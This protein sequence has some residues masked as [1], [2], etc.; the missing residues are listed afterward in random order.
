MKKISLLFPSAFRYPSLPAEWRFGL[1]AARGFAHE[2][3]EDFLYIV[4]R[5]DD[6]AALAGVPYR[7]ARAGQK[8]SL[9]RL[10]LLSLYYFVWLL[11]FFLAHPRWRRGTLY[12]TERKI[13]LGALLLRAIFRFPYKV[14]FESHSLEEPWL[15]RFLYRHADHVIFVTRVM[16]DNARREGLITGEKSFSVLAAAVNMMKFEGVTRDPAELRSD[17]NLPENKKIVLFAGRFRAMGSDKG[18]VPLIKIAGALSDK[19]IVFCFVGGTGKEIESARAEARAEGVEERCI[20]VPFV[21][22]RKIIRYLLAADAL[23][24]LPPREKFFLYETSPMKLFEYMAAGKPIILA[25]YP[26]LREALA[27][28][29]AFFVDPDDRDALT[30]V[31]GEA[32]SGSPRAAAAARA[33]AA[34]AAGNT[35]EERAKK[36]IAIAAAL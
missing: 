3:G 13:G 31:I 11:F 20:F 15:D 24:Y 23:I 8:F 4:E 9:R 26:S 12:I 6:P 27:E 30:R 33:A 34:R 36:I 14:I 1:E 2:L 17:L 21:D 29:E 10:H 28:D 25:D 22:E 18:V 19:E 32:V 35:W 5:V 16:Y 7:E